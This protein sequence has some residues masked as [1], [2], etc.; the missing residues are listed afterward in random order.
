[1]EAH[2]LLKPQRVEEGLFCGMKKPFAGPDIFDRPI[3]EWR[4][5]SQL[6]ACDVVPLLKSTRGAPMGEL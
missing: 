1:L 3:I 2:F 4:E 6:R 5:V